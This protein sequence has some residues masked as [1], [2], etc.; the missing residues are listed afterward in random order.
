MRNTENCGALTLAKGQYGGNTL[1]CVPLPSFWELTSPTCAQFQSQVPE[2]HVCSFSVAS[3][4]PHPQAEL[5]IP[6]VVAIFQLRGHEVQ[7]KLVCRKRGASRHVGDADI[8]DRW[9]LH[10]FPRL[11]VMRYPTS[12]EFSQNNC[13]PYFAGVSPTAGGTHRWRSSLSLYSCTS[14]PLGNLVR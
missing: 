6:E 9:P 7:Q 3:P 8:K 4:R 10:L 5:I 13:I 2:S 14:V 11:G 12:I 1:R